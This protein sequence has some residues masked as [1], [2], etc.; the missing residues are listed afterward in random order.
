MFQV[1]VNLPAPDPRDGRFVAGPDRAL[2]AYDAPEAD[3]DTHRQAE[4]AAAVVAGEHPDAMV[5]VVGPFAA[6]TYGR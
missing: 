1:N 4:A 3:F 5:V 6:T 2:Y